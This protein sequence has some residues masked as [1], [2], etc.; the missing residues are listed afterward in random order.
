MFYASTMTLS[1]I[2][3][4][5]KN[6]IAFKSQI[7][8]NILQVKENSIS[9]FQ[10]LFIK[11]PVFPNDIFLKHFAD[12][13]P[14]K[15]NV[16]HKF[17]N[18]N[19]HCN[20]LYDIIDLEFLKT[21]PFEKLKSLFM[22]A[23][24]KDVT[25]LIRFTPQQ[26][27]HIAK[28]PQDKLNFIK[29]FARQKNCNNLFNFKPAE[30]NTI[31]N[32][33]EKESQ[34][35][36]QLFEFN[37]LPDDLIT[38]CKDNN[39]DIPKLVERLKTLQ[40]IFSTDIHEIRAQKFGGDYVVSLT[41]KQEYK[42]FKYVFDKNFNLNKQYKSNVDFDTEKLKETSL[43]KRLNPFKKAA[44]K[45]AK[46]CLQ[47]SPPI[48][49][50]KERFF[51]LDKISEKANYIKQ[52]YLKAYQHNFY[53]LNTGHGNYIEP[54][55][56]LP[57]N[58]LVNNFKRGI[59][60]ERD[61]I[62]ICSENA[63]LIP[64]TDLKYFALNRI[65][66]TPYDTEKYL[67][68][69]K[70]KTNKKRVEVGSQYY[71]SVLKSVLKNEEEALKNIKADK[72][73]LVI[74]GLPGSGKSTIIN[75]ILKNDKNLYY[76]PDSDDIKAMFA[77]VYRNG[78][79]ADLVHR[80]SSTILK[81]EILPRVF[82]QGKNLIY[83]TTGGSVNIN[84]IILQAKKHGYQI[85]FIHINT[86]KDLSVQRSISRFEKTGRFLDPYVTLMIVNNNNHEKE[87]A[88]KIFS[89]NKNIRHAYLYENG[90]LTRIKDGEKTGRP[91]SL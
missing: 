56:R 60:S 36:I 7:Y 10:P 77:Q 73:M 63:G 13:E 58:M 26:L 34:K 50:D 31:A 1:K 12:V 16:L 9:A 62:K 65:R 30:L 19:E 88:A 40:N 28:L 24:E 41:T 25:G 57:E 37:L 21:V 85:D 55:L 78:E 79:G 23:C 42:T 54:D 61:L 20:L 81:K 75:S 69:R 53:V 18:L 66:I 91:L 3:T 74:D 48:I 49:S 87:F 6:N 64:D 8:K 90:K 45:P 35:A 52:L 83:Q 2:N 27:L 71:N 82:K 5:N 29:P 11:K 68:I 59:I 22:I 46:P 76:T 4:H 70:T 17:A 33:S 39:A 72:K 80:A 51:A 84:N 44:I 47:Q 32:F 38:L 67:D 86:P 15:R 43:F 89:H 14:P